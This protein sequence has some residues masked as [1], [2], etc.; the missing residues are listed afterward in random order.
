[1]ED[2]VWELKDYCHIFCNGQEYTITDLCAVETM[3]FTNKETAKFI[4]AMLNDG[5]FYSEKVA[6]SDSDDV[7]GIKEKIIAP[8]CT[9]E[10][11]EKYAFMRLFRESSFFYDIDCEILKDIDIIQVS[12]IMKGVID[13]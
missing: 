2:E 12:Q 8:Y 4:I 7:N 1:M 13:W 6:E 10:A 3:K 9:R 5:E 11:T